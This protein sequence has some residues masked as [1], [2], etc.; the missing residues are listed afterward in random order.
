M[1]GQ[2]NSAAWV[3]AKHVLI[4]GIAF[5]MLYP[6]LWMLGSSFKPGHMIF[7]ETWFWPQEWNWQN[8]INGWTGIQGNPFS[9][10]LTNSVVLSLGAVLGNVISCSM[11]AYAFAR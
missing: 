11:A 7:T 1:I 6:V 3:V 9:R 10:F 8:Y 4:S 5:V 2:R